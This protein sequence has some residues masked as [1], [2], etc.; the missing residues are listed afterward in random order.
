MSTLNVC[1]YTRTSTSGQTT[2]SQLMALKDYAEKAGYQVL[3]IIEDKGV[4]GG[5]LGRN[6]TGFGRVLELVNKRM[7]QVVLVY[8]VDRIG[9]KLSDILAIAEQLNDKGVG[10]VIYKNQID[11]TTTFGRSTLALM[12]IIA[13]MEKDFI[14]SRIKDGVAAKRAKTGAWGRRRAVLSDEMVAGIKADKDAGIGIQRIAKRYGIGTQQVYRVCGI[15]RGNI[16]V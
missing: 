12:G 8:S 6:R 9:R 1:I 4:S 2:D 13:E 5:T 15:G 10:L 7:V 3:E 14:V 16:G 11:T